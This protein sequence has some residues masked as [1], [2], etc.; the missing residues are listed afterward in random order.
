MLGVSSEHSLL[1]GRG[2]GPRYCIPLGVYQLLED[3]VFI[4]IITSLVRQA[5]LW[6]GVVFDHSVYICLVVGLV[7]M[8]DSTLS[9]CLNVMMGVFVNYKTWVPHW[10]NEYEKKT[11]VVNIIPAKLYFEGFGP[12]AFRH[13]ST[14]WP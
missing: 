13:H 4:V 6:P 12:L 14:G 1:R 9:M 5:L 7:I 3:L 2:Y 8:E 11:K 10:W